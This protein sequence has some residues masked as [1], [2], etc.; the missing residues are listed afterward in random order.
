MDDSG[1]DKTGTTVTLPIPLTLPLPRPNPI[2]PSTDL[3][4][5][6]ISSFFPPIPKLTTI[7]SLPCFSDTLF[8]TFKPDCSPVPALLRFLSFPWSGFNVDEDAP[9]CPIQ[10][11]EDS[12]L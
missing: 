2:E 8:H 12:F 3:S 6:L 7:I 5:L 10:T 11:N 1:G 9:P 4:F